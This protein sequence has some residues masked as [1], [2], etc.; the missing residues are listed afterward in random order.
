MPTNAKEYRQVLE[1]LDASVKLSVHHAKFNKLRHATE[2][3]ELARLLAPLIVNIQKAMGVMP[4]RGEAPPVLVVSSPEAK[5]L[6][7]YCR[8]CID[9]HKPQWQI[10][11]ERAG[12]TPPQQ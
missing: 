5:A 11:A 3:A 10:L 6:A 8:A 4:Q 7:T 9:S 2:D 12:W 1:A